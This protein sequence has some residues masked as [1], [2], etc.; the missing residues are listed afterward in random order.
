MVTEL[1]AA[2]NIAQNI[3]NRTDYQ[4][5][6]ELPVAGGAVKALQHLGVDVDFEFAD[7]LQDQYI[8]LA[9]SNG[10]AYAALCGAATDRIMAE[11]K[12]IAATFK[13]GN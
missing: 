12:E 7:M 4:N 2:K 1:Q 9:G 3:I 8:L 11:A 5:P 13:K 10:V 6:D